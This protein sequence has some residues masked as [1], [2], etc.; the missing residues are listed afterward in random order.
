[1]KLSSAWKLRTLLNEL[2]MNDKFIVLN[3]LDNFLHKIRLDVADEW[4]QCSKYSFFKDC[5]TKQSRDG[6][7]FGEL[8]EIK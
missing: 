7:Y 8:E 5:E 4:M 1:M 6:C 2:A 3:M